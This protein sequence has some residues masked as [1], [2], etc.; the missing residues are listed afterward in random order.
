VDLWPGAADLY[1][2]VG[3]PVEVLGAGLRLQ[4]VKSQ[5]QA[6]EG[7]PVLFLEGQVANISDRSRPVPPL[8]ATALGPN[9]Q[10]LDSWPITASAHDLA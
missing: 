9:K 2:A 10:P 3:L 1:E 6:D 4:N 7:V 5:Q 8:R